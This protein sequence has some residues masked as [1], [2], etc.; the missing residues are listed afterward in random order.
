MYNESDTRIR[1]GALAQEGKV[2]LRQSL[3]LKARGMYMWTEEAT[4]ESEEDALIP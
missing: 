4:A 3:T 1:E 2:W